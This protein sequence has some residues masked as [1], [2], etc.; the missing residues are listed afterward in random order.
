MKSFG[1]GILTLW[2]YTILI[3]SCS[4]KNPTNSNR[5]ND[6]VTDID[7]NVY[8]TVKIGNQWWMAENLKVVRYRN[9]QSIQHIT[10]DTEWT[11]ITTGAYCAYNNN[12]GNIATY[13]LLYNWYAVDDARN[14]APEGWH[15]PTDEEWKELEMYLGLSR[16]E[17]DDKGWR[18]TDEGSKLK[19]TSGWDND[20]NGTNISGFS[21]L[22]GGYRYGYTGA[23][24]SIGGNGYCWSASQ[25]GS[26]YAWF[27][28][29]SYSTSEVRRS[30]S[31]R[32]SGFSVRCV[33]D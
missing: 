7:G 12:N 3:F 26:L 22:P 9:G 20:G 19:A 8:K 13:G 6:T 10:D 25:S 5:D 32:R 2:I 11:I 30:S 16:N 21:A 23:F 15:V 31:N 1:N 18:G 4:E 29:L 17:A 33:T 24:S 28:N 14:I 27:R